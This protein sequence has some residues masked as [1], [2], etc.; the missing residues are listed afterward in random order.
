[1]IRSDPAHLMLWRSLPTDYFL[2]MAVETRE[3][4]CVGDD[5]WQLRGFKNHLGRLWK[6]LPAD[7]RE[8]AHVTLTVEGGRAVFCVRRGRA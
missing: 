8:T 1:M 2:G 7:A 3:G 6:S 4:E 5:P